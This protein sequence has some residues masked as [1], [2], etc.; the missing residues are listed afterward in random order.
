MI[1]SDQSLSSELCMAILANS[2][3]LGQMIGICAEAFH[4]CPCQADM[5]T[6]P[7]LAQQSLARCGHAAPSWLM[8][9][10]DVV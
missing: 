6:R 5:A 7:K 9:Q 3:D 2:S 1:S 8:V 10:S 4:L